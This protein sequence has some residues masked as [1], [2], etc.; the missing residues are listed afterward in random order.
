VPV[1]AGL[2][3][4]AG[5]WPWSSHAATVGADEAPGWLA[6]D[7]L[8]ARFGE[9]R[10]AAILSLNAA[11]EQP[12]QDIGHPDDETP[13]AARCYAD[14]AYMAQVLAAIEA[15]AA[16]GLSPRERRL[17]RPPICA[18]MTSSPDRREAMRSAYRSGYTQKEI[19][20]HFN[21]HTATVSRAVSAAPA[22]R[23]RGR[24][25]MAPAAA[26]HAPD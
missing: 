8:L 26:Q 3:A 10:A 4:R 25:Q 15:A 9:A 18:L 17:I 16:D 22:R 14:A 11:L 12:P 2:T 23:G 24:R 13:A 7:E 1:T 21:V 5:D 20:R 19:A 6:V